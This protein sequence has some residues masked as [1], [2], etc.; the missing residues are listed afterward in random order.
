M[1]AE[2]AVLD[3]LTNVAPA[4]RGAGL[5][6]LPGLPR[7]A[8]PRVF[9][10]FEV[11]DDEDAV[12]AHLVRALR[13]LRPGPGSPA[14]PEPRARVL[15][16]D[17]RLAGRTTGWGGWNWQTAPSDLSDPPETSVSRR[18]PA[19]HPGRF[20]RLVRRRRAEGVR[21]CLHTSMRRLTAVD[22]DLRAA[23]VRRLVRQQEADERRDVGGR[24]EAPRARPR[25]TP[26]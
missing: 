23:Q 8:E 11:Y 2:D 14:A 17:R 7:P 24:S 16:D 25:A 18:S 15:R 9:H 20:R 12:G 13:A 19:L 4:S 6:L 10:I 26:P 21:Q 1:R 3:A 5:P 22:R